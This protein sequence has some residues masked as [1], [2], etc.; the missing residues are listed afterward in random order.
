[1]ANRDAAFGARVMTAKEAPTLHVLKTGS[2]VAVGDIVT[3][4]DDDSGVAL[5]TASSAIIYGIIV[6]QTNEAGTHCNY[7]TNLETTSTAGLKILVQPLTPDVVFA[8]QCSGTTTA[9][10]R[11]KK[12]DIEGTTGALECNENAEAVKPIMIVRVLD[13]ENFM[14]QKVALGANGIVFCKINPYQAI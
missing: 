14:D 3:A 13:G 8:M 1:M 5:A 6:P 7:G 11:G 4:E 10:M 2:T 12:C 9:N